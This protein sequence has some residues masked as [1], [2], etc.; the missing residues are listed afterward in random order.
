MAAHM[1]RYK[2]EM[3]IVEQTAV[4]IASVYGL[5]CKRCGHRPGDDTSASAT[6]LKS[7][8]LVTSN[9][10]G[11]QKFINELETKTQTVIALVS[12]LLT[13]EVHAVTQAP[14]SALQPNP[15]ME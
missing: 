4:E 14:I 11:L 15:D 10:K 7:L 12:T 8:A 13:I 3:G 9:V 5:Y 2:A 6:I 1:H